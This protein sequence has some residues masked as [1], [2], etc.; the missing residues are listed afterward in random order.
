M[1]AIDLSSDVG[2]VA[3]GLATLNLLIG[4]LI[5]IRYSPWRCWPHH[6]FN[7]FR[8]HT[9]TGYALLSACIVHPLVLLASPKPRF[10]V[11]DIL[12]PVHSPSQ[13]L[14]NTI[15]AI[16]LYG[17]V[18][19]AVT[20]YFRLR[21]GRRLWKSFHFLI[22][23]AALALFWHSIFTDPN[24]KNSSVD[25]FDGEKLFIELCLLAVAGV[26]MVRWRHAIRKSRLQPASQGAAKLRN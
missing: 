3:V 24:L 23:F 15:G 13:P 6:R 9:W 21:L 22:Y 12:Y 16:A 25:F 14:E 5:A 20:S 2:L 7:I 18:V 19:V 11:T 10:R 8:L 1:T 26:G 4:S 17:V